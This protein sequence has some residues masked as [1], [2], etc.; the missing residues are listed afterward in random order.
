MPAP[1]TAGPHVPPPPAA[2]A[3][4]R[5]ARSDTP[6]RA[7]CARRPQPRRRPAA[8]GAAPHLLAA[9]RPIGLEDDAAVGGVVGMVEGVARLAIG[10]VRRA[11]HGA[12]AAAVGPDLADARRRLGVRIVAAV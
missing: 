8:A 4:A 3:P 10:A 11:E 7:A 6:T 12:E 2:V 1:I 5:R 9:R